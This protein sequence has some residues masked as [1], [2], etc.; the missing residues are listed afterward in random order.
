MNISTFSIVK[1]DNFNIINGYTFF[2]RKKDNE[3]GLN[4]IN[5][6]DDES[7]LVEQFNFQLNLNITKS[8]ENKNLINIKNN[9]YEKYY[10]RIFE[11]VCLLH[12][13]ENIQPKQNFK[14]NY[15]KIEVINDF[16]NK[17]RKTNIFN[18]KNFVTQ[19]L[20]SQKYNNNNEFSKINK[21]Y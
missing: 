16:F 21:V 5:N 7:D 9:F 11:C 20:N 17:I 1:K 6:D 12:F 13:N 3:I 15:M 4:Y 14:K 8:K 2:Y 19:L 18:R 10:K